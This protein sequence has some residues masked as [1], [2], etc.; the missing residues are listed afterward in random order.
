M[1]KSDKKPSERVMITI[2]LPEEMNQALED[3]AKEFGRPRAAVARAAV[4][5][6]LARLR[7][8]WRADADRERR[9]WGLDGDTPQP[10]TSITS[11][12]VDEGPH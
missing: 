5:A 1:S 10:I 11:S 7:K 8:Q 6:G 3:I 4:G 9:E 12:P 2:G